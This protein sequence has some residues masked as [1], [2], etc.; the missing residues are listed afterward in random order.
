MKRVGVTGAA[1]F[2]GSHSATG[3]CRGRRGGRRRRPVSR[4]AREP[5][6][7]SSTR[8]FTFEQFD[9]TQRRALRSA[10]DGCD[11]IVHLAAQKI[12]RYGGALMTLEANVAGVNAAAHAS[13]WRS[14]P[15]WSSR[16]RP[17]STGT[18]EPPFTED[19]DLVLGPPTIRRW[20]YAVSKLYDEHVCLAL[21]EERGLKVTILRFFGSY[22]PRNHPSWWGGPQ[23]AFIEMLLDGGTMEIHGDGQ[24]MRT[25]TFVE[26]HRRRHRA[27]AAHAGGARRDRQHRRRSSR[28]TILEL[29]ELVQTDAR[30]AACRCGRRSCPTSRCPASTR[31]SATA[32]RTRRR[33]AAARVRG[34]GLA[35]GRARAHRGMASRS[36]ARLGGG[37]L[38]R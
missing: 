19:G 13:R 2:I 9:C 16:R 10:F 15:T 33:P 12:P 27:R 35:R 26:R 37:M 34:A 3:S 21:A 29:A 30:H 36:V 38:K 22:G 5:R 11:A 23:A 8:C 7:A 1:G 28:R 31:T 17:T 25:F 6:D 24:Q 14:T 20:A 18:R 32:S 4:H